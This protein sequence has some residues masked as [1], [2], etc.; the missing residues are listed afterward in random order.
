M[1]RE[2]AVPVR[3]RNGF[4]LL[5][6]LISMTLLAMLSVM[7][8][9]G[10]RLGG[11]VWERSA[12]DVDQ[13][14][15][16]RIARDFIR[17]T[18]T[19]AYPLFDKSDPV[20]PNINFVGDSSSVRFL[21]PMPQSL[22]AAGMAKMSLYIETAGES[23][24]LILTLRQELAFADTKPFPSTVLLDKISSATISYFGSEEAGSAPAWQD[25]WKGTGALPQLI[26]IRIVFSKGDAR[27]W[28][29][30]IVRP[31]VIFDANCTYDS[32]LKGC[33]GH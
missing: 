26:R 16:V 3:R 28:P 17:T 23:S 1:T 15:E 5:E 30:L 32:A 19:E 33:K 9:G 22:G 12:K 10:M 14:D 4:T 25:H 11:R 21:A 24:R 29:D 20:H 27:F 18:F 31:R 7:L 6:L 2:L 13:M 8:L